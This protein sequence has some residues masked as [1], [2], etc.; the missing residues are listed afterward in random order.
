MDEL[1][2][3]GAT[4]RM[5]EAREEYQLGR[6]F[7]DKKQWKTAARHFAQAERR[8]GREDVYQHLYRSCHG[9]SLVYC[10]DVSGLN[11]CRHAA[12]VETVNA[13]VFLNLALAELRLDVMKLKNQLGDKLSESDVDPAIVTLSDKLTQ[14]RTLAREAAGAAEAGWRNLQQAALDALDELDQELDE[15]ESRGDQP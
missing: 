13:E 9:L 3:P 15:A 10:G 7:F 12:G 4:A 6:A 5:R 11:L 14:A 8:S 2:Y 1:L